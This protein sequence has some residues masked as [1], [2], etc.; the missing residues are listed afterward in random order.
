MIS[1]DEREDVWTF[2]DDC[3]LP[4]S[5]DVIVIEYPDQPGRSLF[6]SGATKDGRIVYLEDGKYICDDGTPL[7][8][9]CV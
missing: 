4:V 1:N 3:G 6:I 9:P 7:Q 5:V 2:L 8:L